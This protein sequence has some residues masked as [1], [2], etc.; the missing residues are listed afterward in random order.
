MILGETPTNPTL[1]VIDLKAVASVAKTRGVF[2]VVDN[3]F[4]TPYLQR[5]LD[6]GADLVLYSLTKYLNGHSDV[7]MGAIT[8]A[9]KELYDKIKN[10]QMCKSLTVFSVFKMGE[11]FNILIDV[12]DT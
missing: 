5:P 3:T 2:F 12:A 1:K 4:L 9:N 11:N 8:T 6:F 7:L 10:I